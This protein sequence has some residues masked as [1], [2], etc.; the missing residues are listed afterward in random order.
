MKK[1]TFRNTVEPV[2][3]AVL[4]FAA[5]LQYSRLISAIRDTDLYVERKIFDRVRETIL[6]HYVEPVDEIAIYRAAVEG[7]VQQLGDPHADFLTPEEYREFQNRSAG[8]YAGIGIEID[9]RDG[10]PTIVSPLPKTPATQAGL[11]PGDRIVAVDGVS[12][13][14]MSLDEVV[15]ALRGDSGTIVKLEV[16]RDEDETRVGVELERTRV[17]ISAVSTAYLIE[18]EIGYVEFV[19]FTPSATVEL[20]QAID[21]LITAGAKTLILDLRSNSGGYLDQAITIANLFLPP[22]IPVAHVRSRHENTTFRT[23]RPARYENLPLVVLVG[24][25]TASAAEILAGALQDHDRA[26][27]IGEP[28]YGKG[29]VQQLLYLYA[30]HH[31][32][33]TTSRWYT[34]NGRSIDRTK[35][36]SD[37]KEPDESDGGIWPNIV[38]LDTLD[39]GA[40]S[41]I[42]AVGK[43]VESFR[44]AL[45]AVVVGHV[46]SGR[47]TLAQAQAVDDVRKSF[48]QALH[49]RGLMLDS[50][51][52]DAGWAWIDRLLAHQFVVSSGGDVAA[53]RWRDQNDPI[54]RR[55]LEYFHALKNAT[56]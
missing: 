9:V 10:W 50:S 25:A 34:P 56:S 11:R 53:R 37:P 40:R 29:A 49:A 19:S 30:G 41:L 6:E 51:V 32:K 47:T 16:Q 54:V 42:Q 18:P 28:T 7:L 13:Q 36:P 27:V 48:E 39:A 17:H 31:L 8:E 44:D 14:G 2:L 15:Q 3:L 23:V 46:R 5:G 22:G 1:R 24:S 45:Y 52:L 33:L 21:S 55:A 26:V 12:T 35:H 20:A 43:N 38:V 4:A